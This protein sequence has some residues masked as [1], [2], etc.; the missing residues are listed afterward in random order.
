MDKKGK[1]KNMRRKETVCIRHLDQ[2][3]AMRKSAWF[4]ASFNDLEQL[5]YAIRRICEPAYE[6]IDNHF[7]PIPGR[8]VSEFVP[9]R[10]RMIGYMDEIMMHCEDGEY[11]ALKEVEEKLKTVQK[12]F[13]NMRKSLMEDIRAN[14]VNMSTGYL[15]LNVL[16]ESEQ[17]AI[18]LKQ[19]VRSSRKFQLS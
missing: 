4:F 2:E 19:M 6:H 7:T 1:L 14:S 10:D 15:Y 18:V 12:D 8:Y 17:M 5:Y 13:S 3:T 16:Q 11:A 9:E